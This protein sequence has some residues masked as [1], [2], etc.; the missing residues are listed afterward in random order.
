MATWHQ[1]HARPQ[2]RLYHDT[3][4]T[5]LTDPPNDCRSS[6]QRALVYRAIGEYHGYENLDQYPLTFKTRAEVE[7]RYD[8]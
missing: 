7:A 4:W 8:A 6:I 1:L 2:P 3:L 5:V